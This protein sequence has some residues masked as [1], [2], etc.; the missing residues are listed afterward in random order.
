MGM[1]DVRIAFTNGLGDSGCG[2]TS[3]TMVNVDGGR[4]QRLTF[5]IMT[6]KGE[7]QTIVEDVKCQVPLERE[8][9]RIGEECAKKYARE[10]KD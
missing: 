2:M 5:V 10:K 3:A 7:K 8:A 1:K 4:I 9:F 6:P